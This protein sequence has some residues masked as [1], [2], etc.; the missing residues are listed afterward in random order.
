M[1]KYSLLVICFLLTLI[2]P[3]LS[4]ASEL[5]T[6]NVL[7]QITKKG[8]LRIG[9][10]QDV[11]NFGYYH[12]KHRQFEGMEIDIAKKIAKALNVKP[13]FTAVTAQTRE[14]LLDNQQLDMIIATYTITPERQKQY[15][16]SNPYYLDE[17]GFLVKKSDAITSIK[18][19]D[20]KTIGVAKDQPLKMLLKNMV[21]LTTYPFH[22]SSWVLILNSPSHCTPIASLVLVWINPFYQVTPIKKQLS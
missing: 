7:K 6:P 5:T 16:F 12:P 18:E 9:V 10:K 1:K 4:Q 22:L 8:Q 15:A 2:C 20:Q 14:A 19:L 21:K 17:I 11:P 3:S 13:Q